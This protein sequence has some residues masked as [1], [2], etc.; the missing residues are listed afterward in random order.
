VIALV[1]RLSSTYQAYIKHQL[2][3]HRV[4]LMRCL[5]RRLI[6]VV[7]QTLLKLTHLAL[8]ESS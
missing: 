6:N 2:S 8:V 3:T 1:K 7:L 4:G 5:F